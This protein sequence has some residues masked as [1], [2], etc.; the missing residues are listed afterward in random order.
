ME[1]A[2]GVL[3]LL[4]FV[5]TGCDELDSGRY[6]VASHSKVVILSRTSYQS[7]SNPQEYGAF[8][9]RNLRSGKLQ[10]SN[11]TI[12]SLDYD[13]VVFSKNKLTHG[14]ILERGTKSSTESG[15][16]SFEGFYVPWSIRNER[17]SYLEVIE[18]KYQTKICITNESSLININPKEQ[19]SR[20]DF[21]EN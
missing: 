7:D 21:S 9:I 15:G 20:C 13:W 8:I 14:Y 10:E 11:L 2:K 4:L 1:F 19:I 12:N 16:I 5:I 18:G 6:I 17:E 3:I